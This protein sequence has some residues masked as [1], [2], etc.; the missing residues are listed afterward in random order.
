M[1]PRRPIGN[2]YYLPEQPLASST[3][4]APLRTWTLEILDNRTGAFITNA[5]Q[6]VSWQPQIVLQTTTPPPIP[7]NPQ[8]PSPITVPPGTN[9]LSH[10]DGAPSWATLPPTFWSHPICRWTYCLIRTNPPTG[11][12]PGDVSLLLPT[13]STGGIGQPVLSATSSPP[14][15]ANSYYLGIRNSGAQAASAVVEVDFNITT[16]TND[17]PVSSTLTT[18]D[19]ERYF[20]FNVSS[21]AVEATFQLLK[22]SGNA[23]LVV[24]KGAPLPTLLSTD[25]GSF[26]ATN[27][28]EN[29]FVLTNSSPVPLSP[30][31]WYLGVFRRDTGPVN[32][33]VLAKANWTFTNGLPTIIVLTN[34]VPFNFTAGPGAALTN[35]FSFTVTNT[36]ASI[37]FELY[38]MTGNSD[39]TVQ[40]NGLPLSPPFFSDQPAAGADSRIHL[41]PD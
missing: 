31:L 4:P 26:N 23:D 40:T 30:G 9:H 14:L 13:P 34:G 36:P 29:I 39:L 19:P 6:L 28:D 15:P 37:Q 32:Y 18:N 22:L 3:T 1:S 38:N 27:A 8:Q 21:N 10:R 12:N 11:S 25:Y 17:V 7:L 35:F 33:T 41:Y 20:A 16:L 5:N 2:L 24:S